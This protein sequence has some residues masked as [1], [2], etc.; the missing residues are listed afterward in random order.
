MKLNYKD[1]NEMSD[2][3]LRKLPGVGRTTVARIVGFRPFRNNNDLFKVKGLGAK[4]LKKLGIVKS[5]KKKKKW[6]TIDGI[7]YPDTCLAKDKKYGTIDFF[8]R[9]PNEK[10]ESVG[11]PSPWVLRVRR[12]FER[13]RAEG[14]DGIM[15]QYVDNS[16]MWEP[17]FKFDWED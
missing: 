16:Y 9:I 12:I 6:Y 15:S 7:D 5:K 11:E 4:T 17:G 8:W 13:T 14:P 3:E 1:F 10:R 2:K